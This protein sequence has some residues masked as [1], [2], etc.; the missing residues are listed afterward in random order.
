[1]N[2]DSI[3]IHLSSKF[4]DNFVNGS[5]A[6]CEFYLPMVELPSQHYIY[7]SV[8]NF[9]C[10]HTWY[11]VDSTNNV[12]IYYVNGVYTYLNITQGNYNSNQLASFLQTN[13]SGFTVSYSI[14][15]N[16]ITFTNSSLNFYFSNNSTCLELLGFPSIEL[17]QTSILLSLSSYSQVNLLSKSCIYI[18]SN[19]QTGNINNQG[20]AEGNILCSVPIN[21]APYSLISYVNYSGF[22]TNL[23]SNH[24]SY[25]NIKIV[26]ESNALINLNGYWSMTLQLDIVRFGR[27]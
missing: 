20:K 26:D 8:Q 15:T 6:N 16:K 2:M 11:N 4:C 9:V 18:Q 25:I 10:P 22:R 17:Y 3:Q 7:L 13:M 27:N 21:C 19:L 12:L 24:L 14:I 1:M 5:M 23:F